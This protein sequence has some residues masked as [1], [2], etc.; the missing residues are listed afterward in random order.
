[1]FLEI[2]V[3]RALNGIYNLCSVIVSINCNDRLIKI[4]MWA[5]G[6]R[7]QNQSKTCRVDWF[8]GI[9]SG[10][11]QS[12]LLL[13]KNFSFRR[14]HRTESVELCEKMNSI[15]EVTLHLHPQLEDLKGTRF[16]LLQS[17]P[18]T[19]RVCRM[20]FWVYLRIPQT[21]I[22]CLESRHVAHAA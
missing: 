22:G 7:G 20:N 5:S 16:L 17:W 19:Y 12:N 15:A 8:S 9:R 14:P 11:L 2:I 18:T 3:P 4:Y 10:R 13:C 6:N 1:M 21:K